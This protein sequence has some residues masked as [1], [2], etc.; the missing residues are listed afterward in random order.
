MVNFWDDHAA[1]E[2]DFTARQI[3]T[4]EPGFYDHPS[5]VAAER[6]NGA[7]LFNYSRFVADRSYSSTYLTRVR[8]ELPLIAHAFFEELKAM[9]RKGACV[10]ASL[11]LS[12]I[13]ERE[14]IWSCCLR[15]RTG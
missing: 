10:D 14:G 3:P 13:L 9:G 7:Y 2:N 8:K 6:Q 5:F 12:R 4:A 15:S 11:I 1:I